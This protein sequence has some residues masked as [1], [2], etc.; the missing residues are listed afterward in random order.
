VLGEIGKTPLVP[1]GP[2]A[3][4]L[5]VP[6][7]AKCEHL[8]P[9][10]S[11]KDRIALAIVLD[12][13]RRGVLARGDTIVEATAG[14]TGVGLALVA[15]AR[16]YRLVCV[17]PEKMSL[18]KRISLAALGARVEIVPNAPLGHADNFQEVARR[19]AA[20]HGWFL[21]DQFCNPANPL[22]HEQTTG[23][24]I[25]A[26]AGGRVG[27]FVAGAGTGGT[28]TGV[29]RFLRRACPGARMVLADPLGSG[30]ADWV[31]R[32]V[33]GPDTGY[34]IEGIGAGAAPAVMDRSVIDAAERIPDAESLATVGRLLREEGL[35]VGGSAGTAVAAA[36][37]VARAGGLDGPVVALLPDSWD[38]YLSTDW[39]RAL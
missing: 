32:G 19:L 28:I 37:R 8:N 36:V 34:L 27:A 22:V 26:Q 6:I 12:A 21:A 31:E 24:E 3:D 2:I 17:M 25:L 33:A 18:D 10:G 1:L 35:L 13:E 23:P 9:G 7:L 38:R 20:E 30:L 11:V 15:G 16:G 4:G 5:E 14:N 29:G 39:L